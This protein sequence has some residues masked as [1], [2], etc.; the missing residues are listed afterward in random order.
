MSLSTWT[1]LI[2]TTINEE[3]L[4]M[5]YDEHEEK[6]YAFAREILDLL[7]ERQMT[8]QETTKVL[9]IVQR[10][11]EKASES[12]LSHLPIATFIDVMSYY[13]QVVAPRS[14]CDKLTVKRFMASGQVHVE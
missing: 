1:G 11:V 12:E 2:L 9:D 3:E 10:Q 13:E 6:I 8:Y 14:R 5:T 4:T 7:C